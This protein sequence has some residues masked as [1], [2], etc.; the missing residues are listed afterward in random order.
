ML[1]KYQEANWSA[2][3]AKAFKDPVQLLRFL[4]LDEDMYLKQLKSESQFKMLVPLSYAKKMK[5]RDWSDPLLRQ[6]LPL[7]QEDRLTK[8]FGADPV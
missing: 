3:L 4:Q 8:G 7:K 2:I 6:V 5:K 1:K